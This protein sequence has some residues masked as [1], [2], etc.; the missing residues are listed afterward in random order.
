MESAN[1]ARIAYDAAMEKKAH[2]VVVLDVTKLTTVAD[3]FVIA[4]A[5]N[6]AHVRAVAENIAEKL[7]E[8]GARLDHVEG[9]QLSTWILLDFGSVVVHVFRDDER[10]FYNLERLWGGAKPADPCC[11]T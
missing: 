11:L 8:N 7:A 6:K 9:R 1:L 3:Y 2:D 10:A 4:G 5:S